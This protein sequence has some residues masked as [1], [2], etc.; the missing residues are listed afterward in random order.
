MAD[1]TPISPSDS[2]STR[3]SGVSV[4]GQAVVGGDVVGRDKIVNN[5][6]NISQR[7]LTAAEE[8]AREHSLE[9]QRLAEGVNALALQLQ[10]RAGD[11]ADTAAGSP[12]KGLLEY[13]LGDSEIFFGR[14]RAIRELLDIVERGPLTILHS[15]SGAGKTS[16]LQ[17]GISSRVLG[18]GHL[19]LYLRPYNA[20]PAL[21]VKRAFISDLGLTPMLATAPL[22]D[23][24]R[25]VCAVIGPYTWLYVLLDQFEEFF[26]QLDESARP[27]FVNELAE[28]IEDA[29]LNVRFALAL[30]TEYF[31]SLANFR[32][33]LRSPFE[34][35]YRLNRLSREEAR[36]VIAEPAGRRGIKF[37]D[38]LIDTMLDDLGRTEIAP[39]QTQLVCSTL[40]HELEPGETVITRAIYDREGGASGILRGHLE[41]V[42]SRNLLLEHRTPARRLLESL[43]TSEQRRAIRPRAELVAELGARGVA[44][45]TLDVILNQLVDSRLLRVHE[46]ES[47]MAYELA[48][49]YLL[50]EIKLDPD[51]QS[52]KAA[53][54]LLEQ[55]VRAYRRYKT[56]LTAERLAVIEQYYHD[57]QM[58]GE[59][60]QLINESKVA[61]LREEVEREEAR[62][63]ELEAARKLADEQRKLAEEQQ[64]LA[65]EQQ[66]RA[67]EQAR[68]AWQLRWRA[69]YLAGALGVAV[70]LV[71]FAGY[72]SARVIEVG[73][74]AQANANA[75]QTAE[76]VAQAGLAAAE[77]EASARAT[78]QA[79]A[80]QNAERAEQNEK[81][82]KD[83][84]Q[85]A[86]SNQLA[87]QARE[88]IGRQ[89]D[90][91]LLLSIEAGNLR[92]TTQAQLSLRDALNYA[93]YLDHILRADA[94]AVF[95]VAYS[96]D[97][98]L[99]AAGADRGVL[100]WDTATGRQIGRPLGAELFSN[101]NALAF[102]RDGSALA[103]GFSYGGVAIWDMTRIRGATPPE[104]ITAIGGHIGAVTD[105]AFNP[106][107]SLLAS[108]ADNGSIFLWEVPDRGDEIYV[109]A[110]LSGHTGPV[111]ALAFSPEGS[112]LISAGDDMTLR[113]W[114]V[115]PPRDETAALERVASLG[116]LSALAL[117]G[118]GQMLAVGEEQ[119]IALWRLSISGA[120]PAAPRIDLQFVTTLSGHAGVVKDLEFSRDD[121]SLASGGEDGSLVVWDMPSG[122]L[123]WSGSQ[124]A[125]VESVAFAP[126]GERLITGGAGD[127]IMVWNAG[128]DDLLNRVITFSD[129]SQFVAFDPNTRLAAAASNPSI[130][131]L[132]DTATGAASGQIDLLG[133]ASITALA[134]NPDAN[135][136]AAGYS[137]GPE[138]NL[139]GY[140]Q[141]LDVSDPAGGGALAGDPM[142]MAGTFAGALAFSADGRLLAAGGCNQMDEN[143][144]CRQ[145]EINIWNAATGELLQTFADHEGAVVS[146]A[147]SPDSRYLISAGGRSYIVWDL[148]TGEGKTYPVSGSE[149][150]AVAFGPDNA[151]VAA[152]AYNLNSASAVLIIRDITQPTTRP[153]SSPV[154]ARDLAFSP[155]GQTL[156]AAGADGRIYLWNVSTG[157]PVGEPLYGYYSE[158]IKVTFTADSTALLSAGNFGQKIIAWELDSEALRERACRV[159]NRNLTRAEWRQYFSDE[160][161]DVTCAGNPRAPVDVSILAQDVSRFVAGG[162][163][164]RARAVLNQVMPDLVEA[165]DADA[166][167]AVCL[168]G[169]SEELK[170]SVKPACQAFVA[171]LETVDDPTLALQSCDELIYYGLTEY[172]PQA[173]DHAIKAAQAKGD[174]YSATYVCGSYSR[175]DAGAAASA[176]G[177]AIAL[178]LKS[179]DAYTVVDSCQMF[180]R[181]EGLAGR[182]LP[183]CEKAVTL[184][185]ATEDAD[186][187]NS[188]C[189][190]QAIFGHGG[191]ALPAC[192]R[193]VSL[194]PDD[195]E[196][197]DSR[198]VARALTG[199][200][201]G[202][203]ED[204]EYYVEAMGAGSSVDEWV[205]QR[206]AWIAELKK[207][208]NPLDEETLQMLVDTQS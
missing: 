76:A 18:A 11:I 197:R 26:T 182:A 30:R 2:D 99:L 28:C 55:E 127:A 206:K 185:V 154:Y 108:S 125:A 130:I 85:I 183:V 49:D 138:G 188:I 19:P 161:Y 139:R 205:E 15:E 131:S 124:A 168:L 70:A 27:E 105:V 7:A 200:Y 22:R 128:D 163:S 68:S 37:E 115:N 13:R 87:A 51:V 78:A 71:L 16:L 118:D 189:W 175:L 123:R 190:D 47:G 50:K 160:S 155:D 72:L 120:D 92:D 95:V 201:A 137:S 164:D 6:Q 186:L 140:V 180:R 8:A 100:L 9:T 104:P 96:P 102:N 196:I 167:Q 122:V 80:L 58:T 169:N 143:F 117:S 107:G 41:R 94:G 91:A 84:E 12:Y 142:P 77:A 20:D 158:A 159:A 97:G 38:G 17:A 132:W 66:Q 24:L 195:P 45:E 157:Q 170:D 152:F 153:I 176:C 35:D 171:A 193:A 184:A 146:L 33:R 166:L 4:G 109:A 156:A 133:P 3:A 98:S 86:L 52:R 135:L 90:L 60:E 25:R 59:A 10:A 203:I 126:D 62:Q 69:R 40:Y 174:V 136:L 63:R 147:F 48:H 208:R 81:K 106:D 187:N 54:E 202:A 93:P 73:A 44:V 165:G 121:S 162:D 21:A 67:G 57:L 61:V 192:E 65:E 151:T 89:L 88:L 199:D 56:L 150:T 194:A 207:G 110:N 191:S 177:E 79:E 53:Q 101:V 31:G 149:V 74:Q 116:K 103:A 129:Y 148:E 178:A 172:A 29:G 34:N 14:D 112:A 119:N 198:G 32:P 1:D 42:L 141:R 204:F 39:P 144:T 82:A 5:I 173:C 181:I 113:F 111:N 114:S 145:G 46:S 43:I 134:I 23:F 75:A 36:Q 179:D 64:K 83:Q